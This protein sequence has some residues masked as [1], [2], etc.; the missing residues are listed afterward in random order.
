LGRVVMLVVIGSTVHAIAA[1]GADHFVSEG[2]KF[3]MPMNP[4]TKSD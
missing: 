4:T 1:L 2:L 3:D